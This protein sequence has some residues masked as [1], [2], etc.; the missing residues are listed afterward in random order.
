[1]R[2]VTITMI[3]LLEE[4]EVIRTIDISNL[5][6]PD[7][8]AALDYECNVLGNEAQQI[9]GIKIWINQRGNDQH[10]TILEYVSHEIV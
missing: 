4:K 2:N 8:S 1:M 7:A 3:D 10:E 6:V 9:E 5:M